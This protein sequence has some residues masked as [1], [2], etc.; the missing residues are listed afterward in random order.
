MKV[1]TKFLFCLC[2]IA[3]ATTGFAQTD[4]TQT[5]LN[6]AVKEAN[7]ALIHGPSKIAVLDQASFA[8]PANSGFVPAAAAIRYLRALGN[9]IDEKSLVGLIV[10]LTA[11]TDWLAVL[12]FEKAGYVRDD[13]ARD[14][15]ADDIL[16]NL[17]DG[18]EQSNAG[19]KSRGLPE[20]E[21]T[22]WAEPPAYDAKTH[23]LV[24]SAIVRS[25][26]QNASSPTGVNYRTLALGRDGYLSLTM[27][28]QLSMLATTK[29]TANALLADID[30][31]DGKRYADFNATTD[32]VAEYGLAALVAGVA[33]KKLGLFAIIAAFAAKF[34]KVG[35]VAFLAFG[36]SIRQFFKR[37]PKTTQ[38]VAVSSPVPEPVSEPA[39][40]V[41]TRADDA[42]SS[43]A[44]A[45][46]RR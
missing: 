38:P 8:L 31:M 19:R 29:P 13:D 39:T 42:T 24:W 15:H 26:G 12:T 34:F 27:A 28:T 23:H 32:H 5:E 1:L 45:D 20:L 43:S 10:P 7:A 3:M 6:A 9:T 30:Y 18:T 16:K 11:N 40:D 2:C 17:R 37:K 22:G 14:W 4:A 21:V 44:G 46:E 33:V 36:A 35:L 41:S 25:K